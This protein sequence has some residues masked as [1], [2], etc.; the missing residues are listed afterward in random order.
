MKSCAIITLPEI[1]SLYGFI[2][3]KV[4]LIYQKIMRHTTGARG[5]K[6]ELFQST[7]NYIKQFSR[8]I[9]LCL[10]LF[11]LI[12]VYF[13]LSWSISVHLNASRSLLVSLGLSRSISVYLCLSQSFSYYFGLPWSISVYLGLSRTISDYLGLSRSI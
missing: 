2:R 4:R 9:W 11:W 6:L 12:S 5:Y 10:A 8:Y 1:L 7:F 3:S 13:G